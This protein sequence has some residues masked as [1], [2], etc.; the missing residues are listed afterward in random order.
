MAHL[1]ASLA[2]VL[3]LAKLRMMSTVSDEV[4]N[5]DVRLLGELPRQLPVRHNAE[6]GDSKTEIESESECEK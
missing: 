2:A 6:T 1:V 4:N 3:Q 5:S